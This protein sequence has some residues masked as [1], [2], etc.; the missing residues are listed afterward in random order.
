MKF[1]FFNLKSGDKIIFTNSQKEIC[2]QAK[3][4][5]EKQGFENLTIEGKKT[6]EIWANYI[7][8]EIANS[9][10]ETT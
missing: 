4:Q 10:N 2:E 5:A 1:D 9:Q 3:K 8:N 7:Q 6:K